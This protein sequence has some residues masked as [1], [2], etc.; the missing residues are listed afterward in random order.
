M[1]ADEVRLLIERAERLVEERKGISD[2]I[3]DVWAEAKGRG[4]DPRALQDIMKLR[5]KK[6]EEQQE[7]QAILEVYLRA[8][9]MMA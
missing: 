7:R 1:A 3:K 2:D 9:G 5:A 6:P 4:Y 8:M